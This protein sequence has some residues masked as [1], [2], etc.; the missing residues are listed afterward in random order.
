MLRFSSYSQHW[1]TQGWVFPFSS[2]TRNRFSCPFH[3][4]RLPRQRRRTAG[5]TE[6]EIWG[7]DPRHP[8]SVG[9]PRP[10]A[11]G[12]QP[13]RSVA[14]PP[15]AVEPWVVLHFWHSCPGADGRVP[16]LAI[17][18]LSGAV[19]GATPCFPLP[20]GRVLRSSA[21]GGF[22]QR[23]ASPVTPRM[24]PKSPCKPRSRRGDL[25]S[26]SAGSCLG[27]TS[28]ASPPPISPGRTGTVLG[29]SLIQHQRIEA[30]SG[31][32]PRGGRP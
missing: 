14:G 25:L 16:P 12:A 20:C 10:A 4:S 9:T 1:C 22:S 27:G 15:P 32:K 13:E 2:P 7:P 17:P 5:E 23:S 26:P 28:S 21:C 8:P 11:P 6:R 19:S 24:C 29:G 3:P 18:A 31:Q 30:A